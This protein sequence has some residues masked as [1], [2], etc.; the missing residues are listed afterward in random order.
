MLCIPCLVAARSPDFSTFPPS[1]Q[2]KGGEE[3]E[4]HTRTSIVKNVFRPVPSRGRLAWRI[5][6]YYSARLSTHF[7][8]SF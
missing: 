5:A 8:F 7:F 1:Q 3:H 6:E 4:I 2:I